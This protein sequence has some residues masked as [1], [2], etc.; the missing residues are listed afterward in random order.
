MS[1]TEDMLSKMVMEIHGSYKITVR[2]NGPGTEPA[3]EVDFTPP[4]K[5]VH[6]YEGLEEALKVKLPAPETLGTTGK[7]ARLVRCRLY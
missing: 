6:L 7:R 5:R 3:Y 1:L 4:F 2:P